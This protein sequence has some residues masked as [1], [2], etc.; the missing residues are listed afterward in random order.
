[1]ESITALVTSQVFIMLILIA[2]GYLLARFKVVGVIGAK[3]M[4][5]ILLTIVTPCVMIKAYQ[6]E[7][8]KELFGDIIWAF[9]LSVIIH[10]IAILTAHMCF[11][12][13][14]NIEKKKIKMF[15]SVYSNCGFMGIPLLEATLGEKGVLIGSAYL[16]VF[17]L[18]AWTHGICMYS[19]NIKSLSVKQLAKNPGVIGVILALLLFFT[20]Y[21]LP[22]TVYQ[23]VNYVAMLNTPLAMILLGCY[24]ER[25]NLKNAFKNKD[26]Y[27]VSF[28]RLILI[29]CFA[30]VLF[31]L[32]GTTEFVASSLI[33][34][35]ACPAA[36][37]GALFAAKNNMDTSLPSQIVSVTT[38][39]SMV[40][41]PLMSCLVSV[42][43]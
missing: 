39:I 10:I 35:A 3:E 20:Q 9:I 8:N 7:F 6:I 26:I 12:R 4:S 1:M 5:D 32:F 43:Y 23:T 16:A 21:K 24:L 38:L 28:V 14:K 34:S 40:T 42:V 36:T 19:G 22:N 37:I 2:V 33:M 29:P 18:I 11:I 15:T 31:K 41:L 17:N 27:G 13:Q 30:I 25:T